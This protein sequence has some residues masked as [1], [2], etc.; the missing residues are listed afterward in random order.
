MK[1]MI[2]VLIV[3]CLVAT[4]CQGHRIEEVSFVIGTYRDSVRPSDM[5][6]NNHVNRAKTVSYLQDAQWDA[7]GKIGLPRSVVVDRGYALNVVNTN[8][9]YYH[10][11]YENEKFSVDTSVDKVGEKS[12]TLRQRIYGEDGSLAVEGTSVVVFVPI[13]GDRAAPLPPFIKEKLPH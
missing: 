12:I 6:Y 1:R 3:S 4:A 2:N 13:G 9:N 11:L 8:L 5:D 10:A 7:F